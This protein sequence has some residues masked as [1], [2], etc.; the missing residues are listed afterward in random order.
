MVAAVV[1]ISMGKT[2]VRWDNAM[3]DTSWVTLNV[4]YCYRSTYAA[5]AAVYDRGSERIEVCLPR[6]RNHEEYHPF[7]C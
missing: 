4:E 3:A 6:S 1:R 7:G 5:R 2:G